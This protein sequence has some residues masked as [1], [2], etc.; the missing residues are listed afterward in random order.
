MDTPTPRPLPP[1]RRADPPRDDGRRGVGLRAGPHVPTH[2]LRRTTA[3][4]DLDLPTGARL[5]LQP[6]GVLHRGGRPGKRHGPHRTGTSRSRRYGSPVSPTSC[7][8]A[9]TPGSAPVSGRPA[10]SPRGRSRR[11]SPARSALAAGTHTGSRPAS[12]RASG[13]PRDGRTANEPI[14]WTTGN[15]HVRRSSQPVRRRR[16]YAPV[17][18]RNSRSQVQSGGAQAAPALH[19]R[20][21]TPASTGGRHGP[22]PRRPSGTLNFPASY[23]ETVSRL[24]GSGVEIET[25]FAG[26]RRRPTGNG[27]SPGCGPRS[28]RNGRP[29]PCGTPGRCAGSPSRHSTHA[30]YASPPPLRTRH[31]ARSSGP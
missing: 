2:R 28:P 4:P 27:P 13:P 16:R 14:S 17:R 22:L 5:V 1:R 23:T 30:S 3:D 7:S 24:G 8:P 29:A 20:D 15:A 6:R 10:P 11:T 21:S 18:S 9:R 31:P 26:A 19:V 12:A 25:V